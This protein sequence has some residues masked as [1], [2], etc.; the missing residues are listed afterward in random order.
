MNEL[1]PLHNRLD[2]LIANLSPQKRSQLAR[3]VGRELAKSQQQRIARQQNPD[4][5]NYVPRRPPAQGV[6]QKRIKKGK[7][8]KK[9]R[10]NRFMKTVATKDRV[11]V[12]FI[13]GSREAG[14]AAV[15]QFGK[16]ST[17]IKKRNLKH[18]YDKR[19]LLGFS[20]S[21]VAMIEELVIQ[22]LASQ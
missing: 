18:Q 21:D 6:S 22:H 17:V 5:S 2:A 11:S 13:E 16:L 19:E 15:H 4:G 12:G 9:I 3:E 14:I 8:F 20:E 7:M 10:L 1:Q